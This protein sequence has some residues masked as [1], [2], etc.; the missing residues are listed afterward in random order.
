M[1]CCLVSACA[2]LAYTA[3]SSPFPSP[4][5]GRYPSSYVSGGKFPDGF[6]WGLGTASYQIEGAWD[7]DGRGPSIW[8]TFSGAGGGEPN[9]GHEVKQDSGAVTCDHYHRWKEDV[10]LMV[11]LGL[12]NY[13]FSI[14]WPRLLPN[15]TLAGGV[16]QRAVAFYSAL[17]DELLD[18]G[19]EPFVTLF[20]WDLP[21]ALQS[22]KLR[23]WLDRSIVP[24]FRQ[25][26][27]LC[28]QVRRS[29]PICSLLI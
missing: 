1:G 26:A 12:K 3:A 10:Q 11:D 13:R 20:H 4:Y 6:V 7:E 17:I 23:G 9:P 21:Q 29:G 5:F 14:A 22:P 19:I 16:N 25:Y 8:D 28:F 27:E 18:K 15:G 24:A 2:S